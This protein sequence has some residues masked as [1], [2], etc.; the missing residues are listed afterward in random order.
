MYFSQKNSFF[1]GIMFHHFHDEIS[2]KKSAGSI[3]KDQFYKLLKF[4]G[5]ENILNAEDFILRFKEKKL[6]EKNVCITM[7]DALRCQYDV[8]LPILEDLQIKGFFFVYSSVL[9][10]EPDLL[11]VCRYFRTNF[12]KNV[13]DFYDSFYLEINQDLSNFLKQKKEDIDNFLKIYPMHS[14]EDAKFIHIRDQFLSLKNYHKVMKNMFHKKKFNPANHYDNLLM[15][16][17]NLIK[18]DSLGHKIGLHSNS[19]PTLF[20]ELT[21]EEQKSEYNINLAALNNRF[22]DHNIKINSMS[23]PCGSYNEDTLKILNNLNLDIGFRSNIH[24]EFKKKMKKINNSCFEI[25]REDHANIIK[26]M[27]L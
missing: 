15:N 19:H 21:Y 27:K 23:H 4:I 20:E 1:H 16:E 14:M 11:E 5:L 18:L 17:K 3:N 13:N 25:A 10:G 2:H 22:K 24:V 26:L 8:A 6:T 12:F 9:T 7:D